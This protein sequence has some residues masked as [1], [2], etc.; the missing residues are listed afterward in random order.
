M[1]RA[2]FIRM[3][4]TLLS[5]LILTMTFLYNSSRFYRDVSTKLD[6]IIG[7]ICLAVILICMLAIIIYY[8]FF[9]N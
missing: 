9:N 7:Y 8:F 6:F 1:S 5:P 4:I 2:E 3:L